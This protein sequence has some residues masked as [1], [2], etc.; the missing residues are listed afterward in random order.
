MSI[1]RLLPRTAFAGLA[2]A[3]LAVTSLTLFA[4]SVVQAQTAAQVESQTRPNFGVLLDPPSRSSRAR[5]N[6]RGGNAGDHRPGHHPAPPRQGTEEVVLVDCGG[7]PGTGAVE[8]AVRR[9]R[10]GGTLI[11]RARGGACVGSLNIDKPMT[12]LGEGRIDLDDWNRGIEP[13]LQAPDGYPCLSVAPGVRVEV[14][15]IVFAAPQAGRAACIDG[16]DAEILLNNVGLRYAG[17]EAAIYAEGGVLDMR[18]VKIDAQTSSAAIVADRATLTTDDVILAGALVGVE[19]VPGAERE[20]ILSRTRFV[21][22]NTVDE[23]GAST[24]GLLIG[25]GRTFG[26]VTLNSVTICGYNDLISVE[27]GGVVINRSRLCAA[28]RGVVVYSGSAILR[29]SRVAR[30]D[31]GM[32]IGLGEGAAIGNVF[33]GVY[34]PF[35]NGIEASGN[36]IWSRNDQCK[37]ALVQR[38]RDRYSPSWEDRGGYRCEINDYP[39]AWWEQDEGSYGY[40]YENYAYQLDQYDRYRQGYGWYDCRH[41]YVN[42]DRYRGDDRWSRGGWGRDRECRERSNGPGFRLLPQIDAYLDVDAGLSIGW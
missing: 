2:A 39:R 32:V 34:V 10:P 21:G 6:R 41:R 8:A 24:I 13:T 15:D 23:A 3:T 1:G 22:P 42:N 14:R 11:I 33:A 28:K 37:P 12:I 7:N 38:Y 16:L 30:V 40:P 18:K 20:S 17:D 35:H 4:P 19:I 31:E 27:N 9:V 26:R 36:R 25:G 29:D 5:G